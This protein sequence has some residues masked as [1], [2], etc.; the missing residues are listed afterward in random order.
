MFSRR[1]GV[2]LGGTHERG[3][4]TLEPKLDAKRVIVDGHARFFA[5]RARL[6][7]RTISRLT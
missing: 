6:Q 5:A 7:Q 2:L 4:A 3:A 1:D